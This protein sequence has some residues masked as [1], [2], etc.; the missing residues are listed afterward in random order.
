MT[1]GAFCHMWTVLPIFLWLSLFSLPL[2]ISAYSGTP[3]SVWT[4][5][6]LNPAVRLAP[7]SGLTF[8]SDACSAGAAAG[9]PEVSISATQLQPLMGFGAALTESSAYNFLQLK[10]RN[11]SAYTELLLQLFAPS[12]QGIAISFMRVP[13]TSCDLSLPTPAWSFDDTPDDETLSYFNTSHAMAYQLPVLQDI[14]QLAK[15]YGLQINLVGTPWSAPSWIKSP[16]GAWNDGTIQDG[17]YAWY[18]RY[19]VDVVSTFQSLGMPLYALSLQNDP[20]YAW[21]DYPA[22]ILSAL[23]E[24]VLANALRPALR[25][26]G[27]STLLLVWDGDWDNIDYALEVLQRVGGDGQSVDGVAFHCYTAPGPQAQSVIHQQYPGTLLFQ[28]ECTGVGQE[29]SPADF[30]RNWIGY[31]PMLYFGNLANWG[32]N[33]HHWA[34]SLDLNYG[35]HTGAGCTFCA[36]VVTVDAANSSRPYV[37]QFSAEYYMI[38]HFSSFI[39]PMSHLLQTATS[40]SATSNGLLALAAITPDKSVVV[41]LLNTNSTPVTVLVN[42]QQAGSCY[43]ATVQPQSLSTFKYTTAASSGGGGLSSGGTAGVVIAVVLVAAL[44][45]AAAMVFYRRRAASGAQRYRT[46]E[47]VGLALS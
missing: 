38:G 17:W 7:Q 13:I 47:D 39:P 9:L 42:D 46:Q 44:L 1:V 32:S 34:L 36:S 19:L 33:V 26:K 24:S 23:N 15:S 3:V 14:M 31:L 2:H 20:N 35:P 40:A 10:A 16:K 41:Q 22:T 25:A 8:S 43:L 5:T 28:T 18:V 12:P 11:A 29:T 45:V 37:V 4:T 30:L 6:P 21:G 27:L